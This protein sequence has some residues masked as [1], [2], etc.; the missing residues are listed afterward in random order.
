ME[1][2]KEKQ[3]VFLAHFVFPQWNV[4]LSLDVNSY[5]IM[6]NCYVYLGGVCHLQHLQIQAYQHN[7]YHIYTYNI[8]TI[9]V[10]FYLQY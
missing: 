5:T 3:I 7:V 8:Y 6:T 10:S 2:R 1:L 9:S 4:L